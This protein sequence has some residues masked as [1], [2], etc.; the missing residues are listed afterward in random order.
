M[1]CGSSAT[2]FSLKTLSAAISDTPKGLRWLH[3]LNFHF[4]TRAAM[5]LVSVLVLVAF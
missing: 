5:M 2:G 1:A 4:G 3:A